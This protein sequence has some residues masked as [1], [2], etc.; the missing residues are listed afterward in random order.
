M[1][2]SEGLDDAQIIIFVQNFLDCTKKQDCL[3]SLTLGA[4]QDHMVTNQKTER[5]FQ[6]NFPKNGTRVPGE[7]SKKRNPTFRPIRAEIIFLQKSELIRKNE[8]SAFVLTMGH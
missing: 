5:V 4:K 1:K 7:L 3:Q 6:V 8:D 2:Q